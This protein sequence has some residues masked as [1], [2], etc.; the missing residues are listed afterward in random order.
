M[1]SGFLF[2]WLHYKNYN[3]SNFNHDEQKASLLS[4]ASCC[5]AL[6]DLDPVSL[7][8][9]PTELLHACS[10]RL[11]LLLSAAAAAWGHIFYLPDTGLYTL[12]AA[13]AVAVVA[14]AAI[15]VAA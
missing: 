11:L 13:T 4:L 9:V 12:A 6:A 15:I 14:G 2:V 8:A 5:L 1:L 7:Q 10:S 3:E